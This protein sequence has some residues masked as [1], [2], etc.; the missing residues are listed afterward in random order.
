MLRTIL[1]LV[2]GVLTL[3]FTAGAQTDSATNKSPD[4][5]FLIVNVGVPSDGT[6]SFDLRRVDGTVVF[7]L[8]KLPRFTM[9]SSAEDI[10]WSADG[11]LVAVSVATGKYLR[12]TLVISTAS[13]IAIEVPTQD[14]DYQ[15]RPVRWAKGG[16]LIVETRAEYGG[17]ADPEMAWHHRQYRRTFLVPSCSGRASNPAPSLRQT[18]QAEKFSVLPIGNRCASMTG[19]ETVTE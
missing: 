5:R 1:I 12:D 3:V 19:S 2:L 9:P 13:G 6:E 17:K 18:A 10:R 14:S 4:G 11:K 7:S 16:Q 8:K 15:T